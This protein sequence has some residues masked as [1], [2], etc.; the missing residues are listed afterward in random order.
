[1]QFISSN[2][3]KRRRLRRRSTCKQKTKQRGGGLSA[4]D[5]S[6]EVTTK[7]FEMLFLV[8]LFHWRTKSYAAHKATDE[9]YG[10]LNEH[11][12][13]FMELFLGKQ[14]DGRMIFSHKEIRAVDLTS[15][16]ALKSR[17]EE[18]KKYLMSLTTKLDR[19]YDS[20]LLNVR[21]EVLGDMNQFLYLLSLK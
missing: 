16:E 9:L 21:D 20:D 10:K 4:N 2:K 15:L 3:S 17:A 1:M 13:K 12:D 18:F 19:S 5:F 14:N 8:K 7:F 6:N 11:M